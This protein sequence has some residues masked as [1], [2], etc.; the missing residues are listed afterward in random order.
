M[1]PLSEFPKELA[2]QIDF[3]L[4][5]LDDTLTLDGRLPA[6]SYA[7]LE[8]LTEAGKKV[9]VVTGRPA[10]WCDMIARFWPIAGLIGE[11]GAFAFRYDRQ[12]K[13]MIRSFEKDEAERERDRD[14]LAQIVA[15]AKATFPGLTLS[16]DQGYREADIA[17]D[18]CEDVAPWSEDQIHK[19]MS[20]L[21]DRGATAKVSS[22]HIN[23]WL[24]A[25]NKLK[26]T[27]GF[28]DEAFGL[29]LE[30]HLEKCLYVGDSPNDEPMFAEFPYCV[31]VA[32]ISTFVDQMTQLPTWVTPSEG[33]LGFEEVADA[34]GVLR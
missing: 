28:F 15:E 8:R 2:S 1:K 29:T 10:G 7:A 27:H 18:F 13:R 24:G 6:A 33:G 23:F 31:G 17:I 11:N 4:T 19:V 9:I 12:S 34:L 22:I 30:N 3:V 26:M 25:Y 32:N 5:D 20:F 21:T 16:A 14:R